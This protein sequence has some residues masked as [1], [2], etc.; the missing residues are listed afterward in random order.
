M[1]AAEAL[2]ETLVLNENWKLKEG[3]TKEN[4]YKYS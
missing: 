2:Q 4:N 3:L 1:I